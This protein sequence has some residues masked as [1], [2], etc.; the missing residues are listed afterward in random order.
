MA[1]LELEGQL[2]LEFNEELL[3]V[4]ARG[5]D[6]VI[7]LPSPGCGLRIYRTFPPA[8][9]RT[10]SRAI[11]VLADVGITI[12]ICVGSMTLISAGPGQR[13]SLVLRALG[14]PPVKMHWAALLRSLLTR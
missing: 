13:P 3:R 8:G 4:E 11:A 7:T 14:L 2:Q 6:A 12:R 1:R 9:A 10:I 5:G